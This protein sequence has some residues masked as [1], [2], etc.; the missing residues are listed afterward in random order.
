MGGVPARQ[1]GGYAGMPQQMPLQQ[2]QMGM[3]QQMSGVPAQQMGGY[4]GMQ[5]MM[6]PQQ[7]SQMGMQQ[8][9]GGTFGPPNVL[10]QLSAVPNPQLPRTNPT[11]SPVSFMA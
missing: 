11:P 9:M 2:P 3:P 6:M 4:G 7:P 1:T 10:D 5:Q 8:Q